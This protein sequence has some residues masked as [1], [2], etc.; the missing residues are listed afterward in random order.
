MN[1][2]R[3][4]LKTLLLE[5]SSVFNNTHKFV[6]NFFNLPKGKLT[7]IN[8]TDLISIFRSFTKYYIV[9]NF[10]YLPQRGDLKN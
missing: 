2:F 8:E 9:F 5:P 4:S 6:I 3:Q 1:R 10:N 7:T